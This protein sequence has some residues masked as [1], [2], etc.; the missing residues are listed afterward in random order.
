MRNK[1]Q[2]FQEILIFTNTSFAQREFYPLTEQKNTLSTRE[3]FKNAC[4]NGVIPE[5]FPEICV[6]SNDPSIGLWEINDAE[7]FLELQYGLMDE[8]WEIGLALN[9]YLCLMYKEYN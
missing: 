9:P 7:S 2:A 6:K 4:W 5:L 1:H 8:R 3:K